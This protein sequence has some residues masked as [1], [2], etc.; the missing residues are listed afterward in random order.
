L[1]LGI[2]DSNICLDIL[3]GLYQI[4]VIT[5]WPDKNNWSYCLAK[6]EYQ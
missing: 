2:K 6:Y 3:Q 1:S 4:G 5:I